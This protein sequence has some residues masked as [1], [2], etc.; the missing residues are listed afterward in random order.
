M[1]SGMIHLCSLCQQFI[2][3]IRAAVFLVHHLACYRSALDAGFLMALWA[4]AFFVPIAA[5]SAKFPLARPGTNTGAGF[6]TA[7]NPIAA[8]MIFS[9]PSENPLAAFLAI[10]VVMMFGLIIRFEEVVNLHTAPRTMGYTVLI[11]QF[12]VKLFAAIYTPPKR[13]FHF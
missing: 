13:I 5:L 2:F 3:A 11:P 1:D 8:L 4:A 12:G 9:K 10:D 6:H 7:F